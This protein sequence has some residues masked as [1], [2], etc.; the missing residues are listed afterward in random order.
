MNAIAVIDAE[1]STRRVN[2]GMVYKP[3]QRHRLIYRWKIVCGIGAEVYAVSINVE[4]TDGSTTV[5]A[6]ER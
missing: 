6:A 3:V 2:R 1:G 5:L 4:V